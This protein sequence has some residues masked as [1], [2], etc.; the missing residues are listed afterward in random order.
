MPSLYDPLRTLASKGVTV[1][2]GR[3]T[4]HEPLIVPVFAP[5]ARYSHG[6]IHRAWEI[7]LRHAWLLALQISVPQN[8][9][10]KSPQKLVSE[11]MLEIRDKSYRLTL[12]G[13]ERLGL[14]GGVESF[15]EFE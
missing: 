9:N 4:Q 11:G 1:R 10:S 2:F 8:Q 5:T 14:R 7:C 13:K 3:Q 15:K 12:R 6:L